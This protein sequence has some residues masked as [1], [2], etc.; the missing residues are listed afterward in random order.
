LCATATL[1]LGEGSRH[2]DV[3]I[4]DS[5][6]D[7]VVSEPS[8]EGKVSAAAAAVRFDALR[9]MDRPGVTLVNNNIHLA[10]ASHGDNGPYHG[11]V[12]PDRGYST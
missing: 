2:E 1:F 8:V 10:Y 6:G 3:Y 5:D 9:Q 7:N 4:A 12:L 11:W